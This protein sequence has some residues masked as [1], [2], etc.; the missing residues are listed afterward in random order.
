MRCFSLKNKEFLS[1]NVCLMLFYFSVLFVYF[2]CIHVVCSWGTLNWDWKFV[3]FLWTE[4]CHYSKH[5]DF[6]D[7]TLNKDFFKVI[8]L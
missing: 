6:N 4:D 3:Y 7:C 2:V 8:L 1:S 5:N